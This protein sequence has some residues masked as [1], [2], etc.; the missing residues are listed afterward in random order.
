MLLDNGGQLIAQTRSRNGGNINLQV[1]DLLLMR[2][3]SLISASAGT[4][5]AG[6]DGGNITISAP[7]IVA[8]PKENSDIRANAFQ[9]K[10]GNIQITAQGIFGLQYRPQDTPLSDITASSQFGSA[11]IVQIKTPGIDPS[12]GLANLPATPVD[13]SRQI[14]QGC[15]SMNA[16]ASQHKFVVTGRGGL[17]PDPSEA[18]SRDAVQVGWVTDHPME[19]KQVRS[20]EL[21]QN[22][23]SLPTHSSPFVEAQGWVYGPNGEIVLTATP[24]TH[25]P[26]S[27][28]LP[29]ASCNRS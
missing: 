2:H 26:Y 24:P 10:G 28:V 14:A 25:T 29:P 6:G 17:P 8:L 15:H 19:G 21:E 20:E 16:V 22:S 1:G 7:L 4:A 5:N 12:R 3:N 23:S 27:P 9:G 11:G 13:A 18:L